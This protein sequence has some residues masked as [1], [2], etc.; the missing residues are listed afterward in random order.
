VH[1]QKVD[2]LRK[3][4][5]SG[6]NSGVWEVGGVWCHE[7]VTQELQEEGRRVPKC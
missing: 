1:V 4:V 6:G 3:L 2:V 7:S 5:C